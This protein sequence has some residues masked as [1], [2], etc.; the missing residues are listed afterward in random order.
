MNNT[1]NLLIKMD[2]AIGNS[3]FILNQMD[4]F[5]RIIIVKN[6]IIIKIPIIRIQTI[7]EILIDTLLA[8]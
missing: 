4:Y 1:F 5:I 8:Y 6:L 7:I 3:I 2:F